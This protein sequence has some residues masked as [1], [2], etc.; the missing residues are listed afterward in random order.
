MSAG[1][2]LMRTAL[3]SS[4]RGSTRRWHRSCATRC[5]EVGLSRRTLASLTLLVTLA[6]GCGGNQASHPPPSP[7]PTPT[8]QATVDQTPLTPT[9]SP[10]PS[11]RFPASFPRGAY[12][13]DTSADHYD[14]IAAAGFNVVMTSPFKV[15]L[16]ALQAHG[17]RGIVWLGQ[18]YNTSC[19]W[20]NDDTW[21]R[22]HVSAIAG[23]PA[24]LAY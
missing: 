15:N 23:H 19:R 12:G 24:I 11:V 14:H 9:A 17:L 4:S 22:S 5:S 20:E 3:P 6:A 18:G 13:E 21:I 8:T 10:A 16:D 7:T 1:P 2:S